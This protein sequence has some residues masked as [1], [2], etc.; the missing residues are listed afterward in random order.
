MNRYLTVEEAASLS[1]VSNATIRRWAGAGKIPATKRGGVWLIHSDF[2]A[3]PERRHTTEEGDALSY[4]LALRHIRSVDLKELWVPDILRYEDLLTESARPWLISEARLRV[5]APEL[6]EPPEQVLN[7][8]TP[9]LSRN[10]VML[11]LPDR[12]AY[13][14][15]VLPVL[16]LSDPLLPDSVYSARPSPDS[17]YML[18]K[19][20]DQW[21]RW[22]RANLTLID[23]GLEWM[24]KTDLTSFFDFVQHRQLLADLQRLG[25]PEVS[26][27]ALRR[28]LRKWERSPGGG[29]PQGPDASRVL[30]NLYLLEVDQEMQSDRWAY[31]RFLDDI[32]VFGRT[33]R[34]VVDGMAALQEAVGRRGNVLSSDKTV[35]LKGDH[36]RDDLTDDRLDAI[37]YGLRATGDRSSARDLRALLR[38]ALGGSPK[39]DLRA[40]RFSL[41]R[42]RELGDRHAVPTVLTNLE[43][44]APVAQIVAAYLQPNLHMESVISELTEFLNDP[45]RNFSDYLSV[46][47]LAT[48]LDADLPYPEELVSYARQVSRDANQPS[49]HRIIAFSHLGRAGETADVAWLRRTVRR[50]HN[51]SLLRGLLVALARSGELDRETKQTASARA[52]SLQHTVKY[53]S[54]QR[55]IQ[56]LIVPD[57]SHRRPIVS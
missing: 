11:S 31:T 37:E 47:L 3:A 25:I 26:H 23:E 53:L 34:N 7:P 35:M 56:S 24:V 49:Y 55:T 52:I 32:R 10:S 17:G 15:A 2:K 46:W 44:L 13:H 54:E 4:D 9:F 50:E 21:L 29:I 20:R 41:W 30:G 42:L 16:E 43:E 45:A 40:V 8:K 12:I 27:D 48:L 1:G 18:L 19:G 33:R 39:I 51:P 38:D 57:R 36:A 28:M 5:E 14:A 6:I 22:R